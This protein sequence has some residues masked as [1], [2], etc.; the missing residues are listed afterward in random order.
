MLCVE[1]ILLNFLLGIAALTLAYGDLF[2][3]L[4]IVKSASCQDLSFGVLP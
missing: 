3:N 4:C 1:L 2:Y